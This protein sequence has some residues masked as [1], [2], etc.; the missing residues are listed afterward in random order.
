MSTSLSISLFFLV[1]A[2]TTNSNAFHPNMK[3]S[4]T[5]GAGDGNQLHEHMLSA[6]RE[7]VPAHE[8]SEH[9]DTLYPQRIKP[10]DPRCDGI[11]KLLIEEEPPVKGPPKKGKKPKP[12][13][14]APWWKRRPPSPCMPK[15]GRKKS[16]PRLGLGW[17]PVWPPLTPV[18]ALRTRLQDPPL[19]S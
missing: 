4:N 18:R 12:P 2:F 19:L 14:R 11:R 5:F 8:S 3:I 9:Q 6:S 17:P 15:W 16:P 7:L 13:G 1:L 10:Q